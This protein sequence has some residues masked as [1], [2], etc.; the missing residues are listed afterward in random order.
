MNFTENFKKG[1]A[2]ACRRRDGFTLIELLVVVAIIGI[3]ASVV[4][5]SLNSARG[6]G[7]DAT[8]KSNLVNMR[9]QAEILY[10]SWGNYAVDATPTYF[11]L[12]QCTNVGTGADTLFSNPTIWS[13]I[14]SAYNAGAGIASTRCYS[15]SGAYA[16]AVQLKTSDGNTAP[17]P[18]SWCVDS[19]GASKAYTWAAA[20]TIATSINATFCR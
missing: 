10:D 20:E 15:S 5:A 18:D 11:A 2:S 17:L 12:G 3:L 16:V 6:K 9:P 19:T 1:S 8:I 13:Q 14:T 7:A 4:L